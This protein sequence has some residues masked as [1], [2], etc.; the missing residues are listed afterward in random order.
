MASFLFIQQGLVC[1]TL[2]QSLPKE[3]IVLEA[4]ASLACLEY[5]ILFLR[6][7]MCHELFLSFPD[8]RSLA[9]APS[10]CRREASVKKKHILPSR[11]IAIKISPFVMSLRL[12]N[13]WITRSRQQRHMAILP[14]SQSTQMPILR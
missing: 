1:E 6:F 10:S 4:D 13:P 9:L 3:N 2:A 12:R 8:F 5:R 14:L 7:I 11:R